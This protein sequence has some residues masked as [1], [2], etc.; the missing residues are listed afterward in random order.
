MI[1]TFGSR[2]RR[3]LDDIWDYV[4]HDDVDAADRVIDGITGASRRLADFPECGPARPDIA[5]GVR[6]LI[7]G[8]YL[9]LYRVGDVV[10]V[11]R[12]IHGARDILAALEA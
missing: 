6:S 4:A 9:L 11:V 5:P 12:V 3:D 7:A 10:E 8:R 1:V 2:A